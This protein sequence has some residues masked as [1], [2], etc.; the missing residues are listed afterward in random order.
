MPQH[1]RRAGEV[2]KKHSTE[3]K[4]EKAH[5]DQCNRNC[6]DRK[7]S[8]VL[9][10]AL[11]SVSRCIGTINYRPELQCVYVYVSVLLMYGSGHERKDLH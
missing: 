1:Y 5:K 10:L 9:S 3:R 2:N 4:Q 11:L 8:T 7:R 6:S